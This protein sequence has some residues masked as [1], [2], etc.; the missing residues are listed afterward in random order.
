VSSLECETEQ[1][2]EVKTE[3]LV[4]NAVS[5]NNDGMN[6]I[7]EVSCI[8]NFKNNTVRI[9]NRTGTL[10][11]EGKGYDNQEIVFDGISNRGIS[12]LGKDLPDGTY[13]YII[14]K[15]DGSE[16]RTGY[17]ELLAK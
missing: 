2:F 5:R 4:Y 7:F 12:V 17:L 16:A 11:Y 10:V 8:E 1:T 15:G 14:D 13:F 3:I 9:F 6:D